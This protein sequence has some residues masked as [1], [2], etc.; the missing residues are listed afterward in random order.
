MPASRH[1]LAGGHDDRGVDGELLRCVGVGVGGSGGIVRDVQV[2]EI[3]RSPI[4]GARMGLINALEFG[5]CVADGGV[6]ST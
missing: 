1:Y 3:E 4:D 2:W 6:Q 5:E